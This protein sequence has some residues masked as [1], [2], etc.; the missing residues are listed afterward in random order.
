MWKCQSIQD[1]TV[2]Q[3]QLSLLS[4]QQD[5]QM[6]LE[7]CAVLLPALSICVACLCP[8]SPVFAL[9]VLCCFMVVHAYVT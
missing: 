2:K 4:K 3:Q 9:Y 1:Y 7:P 5:Y 8:I 6:L